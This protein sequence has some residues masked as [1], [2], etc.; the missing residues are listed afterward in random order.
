M[1]MTG[2]PSNTSSGSPWLRIQ[3]RWMKPSL[4]ALPNQAADR[5]PRAGLSCTPLA[6]YSYSA[7][8][9]LFRVL[10][11]AARSGRRFAAV[12]SS[13]RF[14]RRRF[15]HS[16]R[17]SPFRFSTSQS[18]FGTLRTTLSL[19]KGRVRIARVTL[20]LYTMPAT[21]E[22]LKFKGIM[23]PLPVQHRPVRTPAV[24]P[25]ARASRRD[26]VCGDAGHHHLHRSGLH[27]AGGAGDPQRPAA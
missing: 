25:T 14:G 24:A 5:S 26:D 12:P 1:P 19:S 15:S 21:P 27:L 4:S 6:P 2:R 8:W 9:S 18:S 23:S 13:P 20:G 3:L 17:W 10:H 11:L 7:R 16:A 22:V